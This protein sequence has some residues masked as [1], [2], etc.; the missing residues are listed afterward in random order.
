MRIQLVVISINIYWIAVPIAP[1]METVWAHGQEIY[2]LHVDLLRLWIVYNLVGFMDVSW[3]FTICR[4][5]FNGHAFCF[6]LLNDYYCANAH[7]TDRRYC[8]G[9]LLKQRRGFF[10]IVFFFS[11]K[12]IAEIICMWYCFCNL[13]STPSALR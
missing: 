11:C 6:V 7:N 10:W 8:N 9:Q 13:S 5:V 3:V 2:G 4:I 1:G 12:Y